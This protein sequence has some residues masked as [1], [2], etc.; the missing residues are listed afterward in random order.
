MQ[1]NKR[2]VPDHL[3]EKMF[4]C[5][6]GASSMEIFDSMDKMEAIPPQILDFMEVMDVMYGVG[7]SAADSKSYALSIELR[8]QWSC[9]CIG[10][11]LVRVPI[12]SNH[13]NRSNLPG[14]GK[15]CKK[16]GANGIGKL[17]DGNI[18]E[19]GH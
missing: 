16:G 8:W 5:N 14:S 6:L 3:S 18:R 19:A 4:W 10:F 11:S 7:S 1:Q 17:C 15:K 9:I 12:Q 2:R 13:P